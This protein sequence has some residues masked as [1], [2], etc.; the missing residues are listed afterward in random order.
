MAER[1]KAHDW[2]SCEVKSLRR[3]KS[4]SPRHMVNTTI[5]CVFILMLIQYIVVF[6]FMEQNW[7]K[8]ISYST[9]LPV[10]AAPSFFVLVT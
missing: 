4:S 9:V 2:K 7:S 8:S 10:R 3:F 6:L 5:Y 1:F